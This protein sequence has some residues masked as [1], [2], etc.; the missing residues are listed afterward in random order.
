[1]QL[2]RTQGGMISHISLFMITTIRLFFRKGYFLEVLELTVKKYFFSTNEITRSPLSA[3]TWYGDNLFQTILFSMSYWRKI[4]AVA[5]IGD[6]WHE[7][8]HGEAHNHL[9]E[10]HCKFLVEHWSVIKMCEG[11]IRI[12]SVWS[13][14]HKSR[15][16]SLCCSRN[17][18]AA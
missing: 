5:V 16:I 15:Q 4:L 13:F 9:W 8:R 10:V 2:R 7:R 11:K 18:A 1:M 14:P 12:D 3:F 17:I 6:G